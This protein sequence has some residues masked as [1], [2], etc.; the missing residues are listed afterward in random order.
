M[1][2]ACFYVDVYNIEYGI[3][4]PTNG[5]VDKIANILYLKPFSA[6]TVFHASESDVQRRQILTS[7]DDP[8]TE[9]IKNYNGRRPII[10]IG[11]Q[12]KRK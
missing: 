11:I 2:N 7:K 8:R 4:N 1:Y 9:R 3:L 12:M 5:I 6:G 10:N